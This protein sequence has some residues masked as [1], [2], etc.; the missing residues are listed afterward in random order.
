MKSKYTTTPA[1]LTRSPRKGHHQGDIRSTLLPLFAASGVL[2]AFASH[3]DLSAAAYTWN[4]GSGSSIEYGDG[5]WNMENTNWTTDGGATRTGWENGAANSATFGGVSGAGPD[6]VTVNLQDNIVLNA[7]G[8]SSSYWPAVSIVGTGTISFAGSDAYISHNNVYRIFT[9]GAQITGTGGFSKINS[10]VVM[11]TANN[12]YSGNTNIRGNA[13][14]NGGVLQIGNG[15]TTGTLGSGNVNMT[16]A[17]NQVGA[18]TLRFNRSDAITVA[19]RINILDTHNGGIIEHS[20]IGRL[21]LSGQQ[22]LTGSANYKINN[23]AASNAVDAEISGKI[24]GAGNFVKSGLGTLVVSGSDNDYTGQTLVE[25]GTLLLANKLAATGDVDIAGGAAFGFG[26]SAG[27]D[28]LGFEVDTLS[29]NLGSTDAARSSLIFSLGQTEGDWLDIGFLDLSGDGSINIILRDITW[30]GSQ[31]TLVDSYRLMRWESESGLTGA[32]QFNLIGSDAHLLG[33]TLA[34]VGNELIYTAVPEPSTWALLAGAG[35]LGLV[36]LR[37]RK[38]GGAMG[39]GI[40]ALRNSVAGAVIAT[41][42]IGLSQPQLEAQSVV[43]SDTFMS[44]QGDALEERAIGTAGAKWQSTANLDIVDQSKGYVQ[45]R[46]EAQFMGTVELPA[47][48]QSVTVAAKVM[49]QSALEGKPNWIAVGIGNPQYRPIQFTWPHGV[50][51]LFTSAGRYELIQNVPGSGLKVLKHGRAP[52]HWDGAW[53]AVELSYDRAANNVSIRI[54]GVAVASAVA[55]ETQ[56]D[57]QPLRAGFS[58]YSQVQDVPS[59]SDFSLTVN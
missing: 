31:S 15:G 16:R 8:T 9:I 28:Y 14:A 26:K 21:T 59:V 58:G 17:S 44:A 27:A 20:G 35:A 42:A 53:N 36:L 56:G 1:C 55:L 46:D 47:Q 19:N 24:T 25:E 39:S 48:W 10:G 6:L 38:R 51:L 32:E 4:P 29:L 45:L 40:A 7:L 52:Q 13:S 2:L 12:T 3:S 54:N 43:L 22:T 41:V 37:R 49:P 18:A 50:F 5:D 57:L 33:G 30:D 11:L 34:I 23:A